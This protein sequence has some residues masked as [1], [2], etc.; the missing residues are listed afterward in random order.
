MIRQTDTEWPENEREHVPACPVCHGI[1]RKS[2]YDRLRD[3]LFSAQGY[4]NLQT[5]ISCGSAYLDPRPTPQSISR[6]YSSYYTHA[7]NEAAG[8]LKQLSRRARNGYINRH[9][10]ADLKPTSAA[11]GA[12]VGCIPSMKAKVDHELMRS[13]ERS[14][15]RQHLLDVGCG[16]GQFLFLIK[17]A[18]W[19]VKGIDFDPQA[20][21]AAR[22]LGLDVDVG[23]LE[24]LSEQHDAF[25]AITLSHVIEHVYGPA[26]TLK[27]CF[28]LLRRGGTF[29]I[30]TP[31]LEGVGHGLYGRNWRGLEPPRHLV[32]FTWSS[33]KSLLEQAGF[34]SIAPA[35]WR[36]EFKQ[37]AIAS[38]QIAA[39]DTQIGPTGY[40]TD[41]SAETRR[42]EA[43]A[44]KL[45]ESREFITF[46]ARKP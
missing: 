39:S 30:E 44:Q 32:L 10:N 23:G 9:W 45:P 24:I 13:F 40:K 38:C 5:C 25:D 28:R 22:Q 14:K 34:V 21:A 12:I 19:Q 2:L 4:W 15:T 7:N 29:W 3:Q 37:L 43:K 18:G 27:Q 1:E 17:H 20:V 26:D 16:S 35:P 42:A 11:L 8:L 31:N 36:P 6:A 33:L 41:V 46:T